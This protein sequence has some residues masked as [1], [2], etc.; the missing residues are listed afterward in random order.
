MK[1]SVAK[2][3][4]QKPRS[5]FY[6]TFSPVFSYTSLRVILAKAAADDLQ[7]DQWDLKNGF[8]Q[9]DIDVEHM[10]MQ[11][12]EGY[13]DKLPDGSKAALHCLKSIYGLKQSSRLLH[14]RLSKYL[15][16]K[17][18]RQLV[19]DQCVYVK[20]T[21]RDQMIVCTWVDDIIVATS[22]D[23]QSGREQFDLDLRTEFEVS[24]WTCGEAGWILNMKIE[25]DWEAGT[26]HLSQQAAVE[27][28]AV[29]FGLTDKGN[30]VPMEPTLK[31]HKTPV[32]DRI[33]SAEFDYMS[34]VGGLLYLS[35]TARPDVAYSVGV[36]SRYMVCPGRDH[37]EAA[38]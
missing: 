35:M 32:E 17:G 13:S 28:L 14:N 36:L 3:F 7:I 31:L 15:I 4:T 37:V 27:K 12:P 30:S 16:G 21:G 33:S 34:A 6:E 20:G 11:C 10:Y 25:R 23:N 2:V 19:S 5:D 9:Q 22:K 8:I 26:L 29:K 1:L 38:K 18:Y 24:P